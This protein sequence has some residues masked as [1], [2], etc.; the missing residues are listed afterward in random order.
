MYRTRIVQNRGMCPG[1]F[2][3]NGRKNKTPFTWVQ[4]RLTLS[5]NQQTDQKSVHSTRRYSNI[6]VPYQMIKMDKYGSRFAKIHHPNYIK[7]QTKYIWGDSPLTGDSKTLT[8]VTVQSFNGCHQVSP[9]GVNR[10]WG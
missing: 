5:S 9:D 8:Y 1:Q 2:L 6:N 10:F 7:L 3:E 4:V